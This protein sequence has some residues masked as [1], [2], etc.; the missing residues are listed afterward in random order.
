M[1]VELKG[2]GEPIPGIALPDPNISSDLPA[3]TFTFLENG[4][5][6]KTDWVS[7]GYTH[8]EVWC[9]GGVGGDGGIIGDA[10]VGY[11]AF[12]TS[13]GGAGGGGGLHRVAG[14]LV[15]LSDSCPIVV[16]KAG[17][18]GRNGN[19]EYPRRVR[20][21][22]ATGLAYTPYI[23]DPN[24]AYIS[25][26]PGGDG[27]A[28]TFADTLCQ[29]S[30]GKGGK[31]TPWL[32][33]YNGDP[34]VPDYSTRTPGGDGGQGGSGGRSLAGGGGDGAWSEYVI[35][36]FPEVPGYPPPYPEYKGADRHDAVDGTWDGIIGKGG[37]GGRGGVYYSRLHIM[38]SAPMSF[39]PTAFAEPQIDD[40]P[41]G[42]G[43]N[44]DDVILA[45][46][47]GQGSFSYADTSVYGVRESRS[48]P[49]PPPGWTSGTAY[50]SGKVI[51]PGSG[52]GA[53]LN[54]LSG[55][56]SNAPGFNPNGV[57]FIR[58]VKIA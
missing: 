20:V 38:Y 50:G 30:G 42:A 32:A 43:F 22:P 23:W 28:S 16:G 53:R 10:F 39:N 52:G 3:Q 55:Y 46:S 21:N 41:G 36:T 49:P 18:N 34:D 15:D 45:T 47:G 58:L 40:P 19:G 12:N 48:T 1:R 7:L 6:Q 14:A 8:F 54:R 37:G 56:G 11:N 9:I 51:V 2:L 35:L 24:P 17:A 29:A 27:G 13:Y 4:V 25:P 31:P 44:S 5:F 33:P 57:V 26:L